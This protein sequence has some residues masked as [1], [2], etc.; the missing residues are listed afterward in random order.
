MDGYE[1]ARRLPR[2]ATARCGAVLVALSGYGREEDK[3]A[4]ARRRLRSPLREAARPPDAGLICRADTPPR[5]GGDAARARGAERVPTL[6]SQRPRC[7][8]RND[9]RICAER[10]PPGPSY[11]TPFVQGRIMRRDPAGVRP[12]AGARPRRRRLPAAWARLRVPASRIPTRVKHVLQDNNQNYVKGQIIG[13]VKVLIGE[14]LFTSEGDFWR[15]QRRAR[16]AGLPPRAHRRA[17]PTRWC[18]ARRERLDRWE[19]RRAARRADRRRRRDER[20]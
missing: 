15:R 7:H 13:R 1:L 20:A 2:A 17:S 6:E 4:R 10:R 14:G 8:T 9:G 19:P 5:L 16:A 12:G 11:W 18:A 3:R